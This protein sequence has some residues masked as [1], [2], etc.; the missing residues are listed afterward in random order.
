MEYGLVLTFL[1]VTPDEELLKLHYIFFKTQVTLLKIVEFEVVV[2][3]VRMREEQ[4][5]KLRFHL[6]QTL[7]L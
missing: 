2:L 4:A 1:D 5:F 7:N 3:E 6:L